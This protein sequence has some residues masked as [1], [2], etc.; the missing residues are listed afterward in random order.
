MATGMSDPRP[1]G[2]PGASSPE[3][4][5]TG[6]SRPT[7]RRAIAIT[8]IA[9]IVLLLIGSVVAGGVAAPGTPTFPPVGAT[10]P[11]AGAGAQ[12]TLVAVESALQAAGLQSEA[13]STEFR[14]AESARLAG[15]ARLVIRAV[16]PSDP[17]HGQIV[18]YEFLTT[19]DATSAAQEQAAYIASGVGRVQFPPD[20]QFTL[21]VLGSTVV[22]Y[23]WSAANSPD[24]QAAGAVATA[25]GTI[26]FGVPIPN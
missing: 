17:D 18:I 9:V 8:I 16:I 15:A 11:P 25:L 4:A 26:G 24:P 23:A 20:A 22:F 21:R 6:S 3:R 13:V 5:G 1:P 7:N 19:T 12:A 2:P 14:P 10:P